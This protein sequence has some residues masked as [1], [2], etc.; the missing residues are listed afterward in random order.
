MHDRLAP[1]SGHFG[2]EHPISFSGSCC[3]LVFQLVVVA[4]ESLLQAGEIFLVIDFMRH[5]SYDKQSR[6]TH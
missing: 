1:D 6:F 5:W 3:G 2:S 4:V